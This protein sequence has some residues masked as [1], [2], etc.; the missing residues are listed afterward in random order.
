MYNLAKALRDGVGIERDEKRA[1]ELFKQAADLEFAV[2][3]RDL[4]D[5]Y[6][7]GIGT[8]PDAELAAKY[9]KMAES[10]PL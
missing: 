3:Y 10:T 2:A 6:E 9:A 8:E 5:C 1:F 4:A 7:R